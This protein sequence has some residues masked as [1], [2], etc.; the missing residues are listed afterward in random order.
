MRCLCLKAGLPQ[1]PMNP[2]Q[3]W[4]V[5]RACELVLRSKGNLSAEEQ[6]RSGLGT[7]SPKGL[8]LDRAWQ[9]VLRRKTGR[10]QTWP[11]PGPPH[12]AADTVSRHTEARPAPEPDPTQIQP[13]QRV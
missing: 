10:P 7:R 8:S 6:Q 1:I 4:E 13:S 2:K 9:G 5:S 3:E 12:P 11:S